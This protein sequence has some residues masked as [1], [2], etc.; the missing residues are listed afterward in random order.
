MV[1]LFA[2][3]LHEPGAHVLSCTIALWHKMAEDIGAKQETTAVGADAAANVDDDGTPSTTAP[4][5][6][7]KYLDDQLEVRL[8]FCC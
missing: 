6:Y 1:L 8:V 2:Q 7:S 5:G 4:L 3:A